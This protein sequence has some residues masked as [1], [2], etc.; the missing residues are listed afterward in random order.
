MTFQRNER[1]PVCRQ[2]GQATVEML[3]VV[4]ILTLVSLGAFEI[5][6]GYAIKQAMDVGVAKAVRGL[7]IDSS[8]WAW[9]DSTIHNE[10]GG[11]VL[12]GGYG[13][14]LSLEIHDRWGNAITPAQ[15]NDPATMPYGSVFWIRA[16]V[17]FLAHAPFL[18]LTTR[19]I[20]IWHSGVIQRWP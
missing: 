11:N 17:P 14:S 20:E 7:S 5:A 19:Q 9:A 13:A 18:N 6:R 10:V 8:Q 2:A 15:L 3:L 4:L 1:G 16:T 12:G